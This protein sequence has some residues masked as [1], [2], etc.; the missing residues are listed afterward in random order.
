MASVP[1]DRPT[2][3]TILDEGGKNLAAGPHPE[4]ARRDA[5]TL[6]LHVLRKS[7]PETTLAGLIAHDA[8]PMS[9][10][11]A[12]E[13]CCQISRRLAGEPIQYIAGEVEFCGLR[14]AVNRDVLIPRPET[15][16]LVEA[17]IEVAEK[18]WLA[19]IGSGPEMVPSLQIVDVG[20]GSGA[21]ALALAKGKFFS[22]ITATDV[23]PAALAVARLNAARN[24]MGDHVRFVQ[25]DLLEPAGPGPFDMIVSNPP[26]VAEGDRGSLD[27]EV[28]DYEPA[29]ALFA[30]ADGL[31]I[32]RRLIPAAYE[33]LAA[34]GV[35]LLEMGYGQREALR[36]LL[37]KA[38]FT[39]VKFF[40]DL[41]GI[42]RVAV[43]E[44]G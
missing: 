16:H 41:Q 6:L 38:G 12:A 31:A 39:G 10:E 30:G 21:I 14:L 7:A 33:V 11:S 17:A 25:G 44:R 5:E 13:F 15:E 24:G 18:R 26:Y 32:Y 28:R 42:P 22:M 23:S 9:A 37:A 2:L 35:L 40:D 36:D 19:R 27:V 4:R 8:D 3:R 29:Q 1:N 20:T 43:A 34:D